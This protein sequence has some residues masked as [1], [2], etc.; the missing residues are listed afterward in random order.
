M[1]LDRNTSLSAEPLLKSGGPFTDAEYTSEFGHKELNDAKILVIGAGGLGCEILKDLAFSGFKDIECIDMDT[2]ELTNLNRQFLFREKDVG[3]PKAVI[4]TNF[5]RGVVPGIRI[6]AHYAKIQDFDADFYRQ[7]TMIVCGLDNIE[8]RRWINKTVVDIALQYEQYIPLVDGGTEGFQGSAKLIIPTITACF[9]CYMKLVPKQTT[10][11]LCTLAST[12]RLPE[13]CIEWAH[14]LEWP[15]LYPDIPFNTD[16]PDHI[17]KM[18]ELSLKRAH[19]YGIEGVTK[20]KTLGVVKNIIPAIASTNAIVAASCCN[21]AFKFITSCNPNM[22]DTMYYNGEIGV[23]L[24]SDKY[25]R[26]PDCPVCGGNVKEITLGGGMKNIDAKTFASKYVK[27]KFSLLQ[28]DLFFE[29]HDIYNFKNLSS[30]ENT[31]NGS[32]RL[33]DIVPFEFNEQTGTMHSTVLILV[34]DKT[35]KIPLKLKVKIKG[36]KP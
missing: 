36:G 17:T 7:F 13:H 27:A 3:K 22:I 9:E 35:L 6:A 26:L 8:A 21:E 1:P 23:V 15:R 28:P 33:I 25:D 14:Q 12:P 30:E 18:F 4:A 5:V 29:T 10:Y 19:Q 24:A 11:P 20:A 16:I 2:I 32:K 34:I 31:Q